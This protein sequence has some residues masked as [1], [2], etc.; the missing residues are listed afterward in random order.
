MLV[1]PT[2]HETTLCSPT[3]QSWCH[4]RCKTPSQS[5]PTIQLMSPTPQDITQMQPHY[6]NQL[7]SPNAA[8]HHPNAAPNQLVPPLL[9]YTTPMR[10]ASR[11]LD[12]T[13]VN[14]NS[15]HQRCIIQVACSPKSIGPTHAALHH[16]LNQKKR[17]RAPSN[18]SRKITI[19]RQYSN[20]LTTSSRTKPC[21]PGQTTRK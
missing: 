20:Q 12:N 4:P 9:H 17:S 11:A 5:G 21:F 16:P 18:Q 7:M 10:L 15:Y 14:L 13:R 1:P 19:T 6:P 3:I 8:R 2:L